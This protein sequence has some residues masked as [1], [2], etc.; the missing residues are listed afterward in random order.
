MGPS[1][2]AGGSSSEAHGGA[3]EVRDGVGKALMEGIDERRP[4]MAGAPARASSAQLE[5]R[6]RRRKREGESEREFITLGNSK[7]TKTR[8]IKFQ[9]RSIRKNIRSIRVNPEF[10]VSY[11]E[12]PGSPGSR[13]LD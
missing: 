7:R 1:I 13:I 6:R 12:Y 10:P 5:S 11:P 2:P 4:E 3:A 8:D 9:A